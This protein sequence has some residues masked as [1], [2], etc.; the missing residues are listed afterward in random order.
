[1]GKGSHWRK[2]LAETDNRHI[3]TGRMP[4]T[5]PSDLS[6]GRGAAA[7]PVVRERGRYGNKPLHRAF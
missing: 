1:M 4:L 2:L 5:W 6:W 3:H 7:C